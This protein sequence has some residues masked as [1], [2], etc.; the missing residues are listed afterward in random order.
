MTTAW[1]YEVFPAPERHVSER[2]GVRQVT[3]SVGKDY[4]NRLGQEGWELAAINGSHLIF[5]R[6]QSA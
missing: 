1:E 4:L 5:K 2:N 3:I 6:L